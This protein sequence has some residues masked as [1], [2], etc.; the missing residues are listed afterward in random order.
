MG[1]DDFSNLD[2]T[3]QAALVTSGECSA[4][5]LLEATIDG[6]ERVNPQLNAVIIPLFDR[7]REQVARGDL[8]DGPFRGVPLVLKDLGASLAGTPQYGGTKVLRDRSWISPA[9]S[10]L[11]ARFG[12]AG[13]VFVGKTNTP[14]LGLSPTTEPETFGPTR[15]P[16]NP[17]RIV[18]GSSGGSAAA[19]AAR[20]VAVAHAGDGGG[21]IRNPAG[22]CGVMG[23]KPSRGRVTLGPDAGESWSGCVTELV[24]TR[25]VRDTAAV[26]DAVA[27]YFTGDPV[28]AVPPERSYLS[29]V[30]RESGRLRVG[31]F[32]GN[33]ETPGAPEA[34]DAVEGCA[35]LLT[36]LGHDVHDGYPSV[37]DSN[38]LAS[39]LGVSVAVS[40]A[41][42]LAVIEERTGS[43]VGPDGVEPATWMFAERGRATSAVDYV[44]N[45]DAMHRYSRT[46]CSWWDVDGNDLLIT[47]TMAEAAPPIGELKGASVER[48]VRL[49]PYTSPYNVSGQPGIA[50]PLHWTRD[51]MPVGIQLIAPIG[52]ED[53]LIRVA[54]QLEAAQP[55]QDRVPPI[56]A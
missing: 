44:A 29:E 1:T 10:E 38:E 16:W 51:D 40:V 53:M 5:E 45:I 36:D 55:W 6:I 33:P 39:L 15:N 22:A 2:A 7:A 37:L 32:V 50:L 20:M 13:F 35:R 14:E 23:L 28:T 43:P 47:P 25:S 49:V 54:A 18:G 8:G 19:V 12:R 31:M 34:R 24:I 11:T 48:I 17:D 56:H 21:S 30:G 3:A 9:D 46:L 42:E 41:R 27:G 52:R 26:L 4:A